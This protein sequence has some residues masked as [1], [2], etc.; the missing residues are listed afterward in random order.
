[1][2]LFLILDIPVETFKLGGWLIYLFI[3]FDGIDAETNIFE[4][5]GYGFIDEV[6]V[7]VVFFMT[8]P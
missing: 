2:I 4:E 8:D 7:W 5:I 1:M 3:G 6:I